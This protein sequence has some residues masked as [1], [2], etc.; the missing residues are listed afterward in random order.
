MPFRIYVHHL[1]IYVHAILLGNI[2][3]RKIYKMQQKFKHIYLAEKHD[4]NIM[5][6]LRNFIIIQ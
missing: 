2:M 1:Y 6:S 3:N 4:K 5:E